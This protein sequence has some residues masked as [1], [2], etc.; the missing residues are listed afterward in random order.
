MRLNTICPYFKVR[1]HGVDLIN[2]TAYVPVIRMS[3]NDD[4]NNNNNYM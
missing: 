1:K 3:T 4:N 2:I